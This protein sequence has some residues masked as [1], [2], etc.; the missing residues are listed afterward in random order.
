MKKYLS[1]LLVGLMAAVTVGCGGS[2]SSSS[3]DQSAQPAPQEQKQ[4]A[5]KEEKKSDYPNGPISLIVSF[6]A[7]GG[8]D[9]GARILAPFVEKE[10]GVPVNI[11]N[12]PGG[13]GWVGWAELVSTKPDGYTIGYINTP[14]IITGYVNPSFQR[15][16]NLDSFAPIANHV[17]DSGAIAIR[18]DETRF[19]NI[20]ELI[21][22][23]KSNEL[24]TTST[25]VGSDDHYAAL[26]VNKD[27]GTKFRAVHTGGFGENLSNLLGGH[28]DVMFANVGEV[29]TPFKEGQFKVIGVMS[30]ERS[31][32]LPDVP[33]LKESGIG[34]IFSWSARGIA[35]PAGV[36][37]AVLEKLQAAFEKAINDPEQKKKMEEMGLQVD[38]RKGNDY[39]KM[40]KEEE[41]G[42]MELKSLLGW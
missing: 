38:F 2:P 5:P 31:P 39:A 36:D 3:S 32:Y 12:K 1:F 11:V 6:G 17:T 25:G 28:V 8:T 30:E 40:L 33:T 22:Y 18:K 13:G 21:E 41:A 42:V 35:A 34:D 20:N 29:V 26:K 16:E 15:K 7:G 23:A 9:L 19:T 14:N 10:L 27:A 4:E 37:P 24:T